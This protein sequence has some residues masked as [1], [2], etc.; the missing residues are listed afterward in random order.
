MVLPQLAESVMGLLEKLPEYLNRTEEWLTVHLFSNNP[1]LEGNVQQLYASVSSS[2]MEW[3]NT[4]LVPQ[5]LEVMR[6][7]RCV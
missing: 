7:N 1:I 2:L 4:Q 3:A 5:L 6:G